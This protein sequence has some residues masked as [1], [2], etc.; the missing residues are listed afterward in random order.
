MS[1]SGR[2]R[3]AV[4]A[5][6]AWNAASRMRLFPIFFV[7]VCALAAPAAAQQVT[8]DQVD[9]LVARA[10][11]AEAR[12]RLAEWWKTPDRA[13]EARALFLRARLATDPALAQGDYLALVLGHPD[14]PQRPAALLYLGQGFFGVGDYYRAVTYLER[15]GLD[16]PGNAQRPTG[17]LW[18][19]RSHL[20]AGRPNAACAAARQGRT[21]V[22]DPDLVALFQIEE[23]EACAIA[24]G[25][26]TDKPLT[27][28][29]ERS[30]EDH[31]P[32]SSAQRFALQVGAF[33]EASG[34]AA[35]GR[36]LSG[37]G[38]EPRVVLVPGS[39]LRRVRIGSFQT[40]AE[41]DEM[42]RKV[43]AAGFD[44]VVV[45]DVAAERTA[46]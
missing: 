16:Y 31:A 12:A 3:H 6:V 41:A 29:A 4:I 33:R 28:L 35:L 10:S 7:L 19:A 25:E 34:A 40:A 37:A 15:L 38:F 2:T 22:R 21:L 43:R 13:Q 26:I 9:S 1:I 27:P 18:L 39:S 42:A 5:A 30:Q 20:A 14:A 11:Y 32:T 36:Q 8:L 46:S 17:A 44:I 45:S 23:T 24:S